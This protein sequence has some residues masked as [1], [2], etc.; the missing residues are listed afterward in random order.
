[1]P[2]RTASASPPSASRTH[3]AAHRAPTEERTCSAAAEAARC[4][5]FSVS[6]DAASRLSSAS[7]R[8]RVIALSALRRITPVCAPMMT[9]TSRKTTSVAQSRDEETATTPYGGTKKY[10]IDAKDS[11]EA[12]SDAG[13]P[14]SLP[15]RAT[16]GMSS[17]GSSPCVIAWRVSRSSAVASA[18]TT[19]ANACPRQPASER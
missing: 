11:A 14:A 17:R 16:I 6:R 7:E 15:V 3:T 12:V 13:K 9:A 18:T 8:S 5:D 19:T 10:R 1:M 4:G 2:A